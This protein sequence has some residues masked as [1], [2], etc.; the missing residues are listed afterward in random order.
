[1]NVKI[2]LEIH[3]QL[4][5]E[6]KLFCGDIVKSANAKP[7]EN[8]C[9][10]CLGFPGYKPKINRNALDFAIMAALALECNIN[11]DALFSRK[12]YFY[13]DLSKNYQITQYE[14]PLAESGHLMVKDKKIRIKR[15]HLEED[16]AQIAYVGGDITSA[17]YT[18]INYNRAGTPLVEIVTEPDFTSPKEAREFLEK[19][20]SI[21]DHLGVYEPTKEGSIRIDANIS[22][23]GERVELKNITGFE[24]VEKALSFE[25]LRQNG[26]TRMQESIE[27]ETRHFDADTNTTKKLRSK[28][29]EEDYG[30]IFDPDL[31][32][33]KISKDWIDSI[34]STMP[35]LPDIRITRFV[36]EYGI[37]EYDARVIVYYDKNLADFF[38]KCCKLYNKPKT[39]IN[40]IANYLIKS[41]NWR[42]ER[43]KDSK[44][45]P[46]TF[47]ELLE[48]MDKKEVTERYAKELIKEYVDTGTSPKELVKKNK[49]SITKDE[50]RLIVKDVLEKNKKASEDLKVGKNDAMQFL[51]GA[52][53]SQTKKQGDPIVIKELIIEYLKS[54]DS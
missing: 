44:V 9:P 17:E 2:G 54:K 36:K 13:P 46:E 3:C 18:L 6:T 32:S 15:L 50:L 23:Q 26:L 45:S 39:I 5:T 27:R 19:L 20:S 49:V 34:S 8:T 35:E 12:T 14:M 37:D 16:P 51:I 53:L 24:N 28:E 22:T 25:M 7:N 29:Y 1:M 11:N 10:I 38:E 21:L 33:I 30:Y 40:W 41:L 43:I 48:L 52:I 47:I 4:N 42:G 31:P